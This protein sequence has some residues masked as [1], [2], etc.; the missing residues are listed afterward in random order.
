M[1]KRILN[2]EFALERR[3]ASRGVLRNDKE[4]KKR[5]RYENK[6]KAKKKRR[7]NAIGDVTENTRYFYRTPY[8]EREISCYS[9]HAIN[10]QP[11]NERIRIQ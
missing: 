3:E 2:D 7:G 1:K 5:K 8:T 4:S 11:M 9:R 6:K 10:F